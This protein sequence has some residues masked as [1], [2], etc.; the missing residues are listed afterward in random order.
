MAKQ[1]RE[2]ATKKKRVVSKTS[3]KSQSNKKFNSKLS[4]D[5]SKI[6]KKNP[7]TFVILVVFLVI[8]AV[9]GYFVVNKIGA[10]DCYEIKAYDYSL[11]K[12]N[13]HDETAKSLYGDLGA[14]TAIIFVDE[15]YKE[16]GVKCIAFGRDCSNECQVTYYYREDISHDPVI[17]DKVDSSVAGFYYAV[18]KSPAFKY[19]DVELIRNIIVVEVEN[20]G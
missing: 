8:G 20:D 7:L 2:L 3:S 10:N 12:K 14:E 1:P 13:I 11:A 9:A 5:I 16:E 19:K 18:Y 4:K 15:T 17:K 6:A